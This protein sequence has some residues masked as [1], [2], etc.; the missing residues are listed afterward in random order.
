MAEPADGSRTTSAH[1]SAII[2]RAAESGNSMMS[3]TFRADRS[4]PF[5]TAASFLVRRTRIIFVNRW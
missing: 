3:P 2:M 5:T 4:T 1:R